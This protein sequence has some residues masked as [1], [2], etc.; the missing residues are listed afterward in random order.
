MWI[1][2][3]VQLARDDTTIAIGP[4]DAGISVTCD[5]FFRELLF[6]LM[7]QRWITNGNARLWH[8]SWIFSGEHTT[9]Q[10][11]WSMTWI[12]VFLQWRFE[13][14]RSMQND[15]VDDPGDSSATATITRTQCRDKHERWIHRIH[16]EEMEFS[17]RNVL[18]SSENISYLCRHLRC[19]SKL[20]YSTLHA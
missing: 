2:C 12:A 14:H 1:S 10:I 7:R 19:Y 18:L 20:I 16:S 8:L 11:L 17:R 13:R 5:G 3:I 15:V 9:T 4:L 6:R